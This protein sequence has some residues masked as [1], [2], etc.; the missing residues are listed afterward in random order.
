MFFC[1]LSFSFFGF[2]LLVLFI[3]ILIILQLFSK[4]YTTMKRK[5][6]SLSYEHKRLLLAKEK[7]FRTTITTTT[8]DQDSLP[9]GCGVHRSLSHQHI[10]SLKTVCDTIH[11]QVTDTVS[12]GEGMDDKRKRCYGFI[13]KYS[14]W[15]NIQQLCDAGIV[16]DSE[17]ATSTE[18]E[19]EKEKETLSNEDMA[20]P[21]LKNNYN[22][23]S[24]S[25]NKHTF[26]VNNCCTTISLNA[27]QKEAMDYVITLA[28]EVLRANTDHLQTFELECLDISQLVSIQ[29]N[30]HNHTAYLPLHLDE[31]R[32]DGFGVV[33]VTGK[34]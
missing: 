20:E 15:K 24:P 3:F 9:R 1:L 33:I 13:D 27:A 31:P 28:K 10:E 14:E 12:W 17:T 2:V 5:R 29:P 26:T 16:M 25:I 18:K 22:H 32:H 19:K 7:A 4:L 8:D 30:V 6:Q 34:V 21:D 23:I 11:S